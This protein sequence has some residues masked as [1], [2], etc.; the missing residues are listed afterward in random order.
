[1]SFL[2]SESSQI[3]QPV[4]T[5]QE[6]VSPTF[7][8]NEAS[9]VRNARAY[10]IAWH[11]HHPITCAGVLIADDR[12]GLVPE[13]AEDCV[14]DPGLLDK[15]EL[16]LD[17]GINADK[18]KSSFYIVLHQVVA[19]AMPIGTTAPHQAMASD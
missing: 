7:H 6:E 1:M 11:S 17:V 13:S 4:D 3:T 5:R 12:I 8:R 15:F 18:V 10:R 16:T 14:V 19:Y 9:Q 2:A